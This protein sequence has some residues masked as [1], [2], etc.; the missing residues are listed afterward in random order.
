MKDIIQDISLS[1]Q[2]D[3]VGVGELEWAVKLAK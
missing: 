2:R 3:L 1:I